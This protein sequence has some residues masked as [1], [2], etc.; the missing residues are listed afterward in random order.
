VPLFD[1]VTF[2][3][4]RYSQLWGTIPL[5]SLENLDF[6]WIRSDPGA[7]VYWP[8]LVLNVLLVALSGCTLA[9][10]ASRARLAPGRLLSVLVALA[11]LVVGSTAFSL[12]RHKH[13]GHTDYVDMLRYLQANSTPSDVIVQNGPQ[14]TAVLQ[15][16]YKG[17]LPGYGLFEGQQPLS[18]D[19]LAVL[20]R[21]AAGHPRVWL[22]PDN[23]PPQDSSLDR[24]FIERGWS[25][26]HSSFGDQRLTL[27]SRP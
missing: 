1:A 13:D 21:L 15:N 25:P 14:D 24:W 7:I 11:L 5:L 18:A 4:P 2:F 6:A 16:H 17:H 8:S 22:I 12:A 23:L 20:Q 19:A 26:A 3:D 27:Y 10:V 9:I